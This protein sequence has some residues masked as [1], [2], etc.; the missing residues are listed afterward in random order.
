MALGRVE[1]V[2]LRKICQGLFEKLPRACIR[3]IPHA[4]SRHAK[5]GVSIGGGAAT[6]VVLSVVVLLPCTS[7]THQHHCE[8]VTD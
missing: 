8:L 6:Y 5:T 3:D 4:S 2:F 7:N 1:L